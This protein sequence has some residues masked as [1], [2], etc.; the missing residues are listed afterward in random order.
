MHINGATIIAGH[1]NNRI[2]SIYLT[3][4]YQNLENLKK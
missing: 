4:T 2:I 3:L 1:K